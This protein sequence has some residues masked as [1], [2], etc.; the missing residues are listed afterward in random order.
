[1][2]TKK[3]F[4]QGVLITLLVS[5]VGCTPKS[6]RNASVADSVSSIEEI[7]EEIAEE[8]AEGITETKS[9]FL[10]PAGFVL[11]KEIH[12]DLNKDGLEDC[13]VIMKGTDKENFVVDEYRGKLDRNRRGIMILFNKGDDRYEVKAINL[14]CFS[15]ENEDGG[16]YFPPELWV[17][18]EK[19]NLYFHYGHGRYG[20]WKYTFRHKDNDFELIGYDSGNHRGPVIESEVSI[21]FLTKKKLNRVNVNEDAEGGDEVFEETW[22]NIDVRELIKLSEINDFDDFDFYYGEI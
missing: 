13:V 5:A 2:K 18:I 14:T 11:F 21:N 8:V 3:Y 20:Y 19:G 4:R 6:M 9:G 12:G 10:L 1:M 16:V 22:S 7:P 17:Y 15:S